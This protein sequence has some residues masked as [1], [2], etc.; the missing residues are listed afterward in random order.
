MTPTVI[1]K[2]HSHFTGL[3]KCHLTRDL[4]LKTSFLYKFSSEKKD[5]RFGNYLFLPNLLYD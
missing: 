2:L 5:H 3:E 1:E 4:F